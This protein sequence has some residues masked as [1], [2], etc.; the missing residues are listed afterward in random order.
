MNKV[1]LFFRVT[2]PNICEELGQ[3]LMWEESVKVQKDESC[4]NQP[5]VSSRIN[6]WK[7]EMHL[8]L[9]VLI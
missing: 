3:E 8:V 4:V 9:G 5:R 2:V 7:S 6:Q 1:L